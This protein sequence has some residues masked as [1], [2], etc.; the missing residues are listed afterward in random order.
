MG[1]AA[2][3]RRKLKISEWDME[4]PGLVGIES[5]WEAR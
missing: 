1:I 5:S 2:M 4:D 3:V